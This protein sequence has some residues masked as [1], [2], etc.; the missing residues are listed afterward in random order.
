MNTPPDTYP[1]DVMYRSLRSV[2]WTMTHYLERTR[3]ALLGPGDR[4]ALASF[5]RSGNT[6]MRALIERATGEQT[7]SVY[8]EGDKVM[9]R[10]E[11]GIV[12]KTHQRDAWRYGRVIHL[13]RNPFD[14]VES[15]YHFY[16]RSG[17]TLS[18]DDHVQKWG[19]KWGVNT[20][21]WLNV[22]TPTLRF[23][24]EDLYHNPENTLKRVLDWLEVKTPDVAVTN[25][26]EA[27][28]LE[29]L[30]KKAPEQGKHY[31]R[32]GGI[33]KSLSEYSEKQIQY[34]HDVNKDLF[35]QFG[36]RLLA[37]KEQNKIN[38]DIT[39]G[40]AISRSIG[41]TESSAKRKIS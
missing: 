40:A 12:I 31:F 34:L 32:R 14:A 27:C 2:K 9:Q 28:R 39:S 24:Y 8:G 16:Q 4:T 36:Y 1:L 29:R 21:Y 5:P 26:V 11:D 33:G 22:D 38:L 17:D 25:A 15:L 37:R 3:F 10:D 35:D 41:S 30:K 20:R 18:W 7:G 13:V 19:R 6:W 23:R